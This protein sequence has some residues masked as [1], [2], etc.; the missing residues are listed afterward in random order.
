MTEQSSTIRSWREQ[1]L[2]AAVHL[3]CPQCKAPG[4]FLNN[5]HIRREFPTCYAEPGDERYDT[6]V[7]KTCPHC[8]AVRDPTLIQRLGEIWRRRFT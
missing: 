7:G 5:E 1:G 3:A 8:G 4:K 6:P 2:I